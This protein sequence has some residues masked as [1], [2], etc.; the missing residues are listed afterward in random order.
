MGQILAER[1]EDWH[2]IW[3]SPSALWVFPLAFRTACG[4]H[5]A[6]PSLTTHRCTF[7]SQ[8]GWKVHVCRQTSGTWAVL[9]ARLPR[10]R[11]DRSHFCA[12]IGGLSSLAPFSFQARQ[13]THHPQA[14]RGVAAA[15]DGGVRPC[16][17]AERTMPG[18]LP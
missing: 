9:V 1:F 6:S 8:A 11:K 14:A 4:T 16:K 2:D 17:T 12:G 3:R 10:N 15:V 13:E 5:L 7:Q 18:T